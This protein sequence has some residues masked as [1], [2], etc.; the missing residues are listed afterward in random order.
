MRTAS[1]LTAS[2]HGIY[3][4]RQP[5]PAHL[6]PAKQASDVKLS[7][8]TRCPKLAT[9][10]SHVLILA[11]QALLS[12][13]T[14]LDIKYEDIR[15]HVQNHFRRRLA[16]FKNQVNELGPISD[17]RVKGL[18]DVIRAADGSRETFVNH[19]NLDDSEGL[20]SAFCEQERISEVLTREDT[21]LILQD[22]QNAYGQH[23]KAALDF[24]ASFATFILEDLPIAA[25]KE[26]PSSGFLEP[27]AA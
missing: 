14:I 1:Y 22:Y 26:C 18:K 4:F 17:D 3:Y 10:F 20:I 12:Q 2:R 23:A 6:H 19:I 13:T 16:T 21:H 27:M 11:G 25:S 7:L 15:T 5:L 8:G 24:N 9:H